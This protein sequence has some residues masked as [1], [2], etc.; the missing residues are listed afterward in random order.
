MRLLFSSLLALTLGI[1][2]VGCCHTS[3]FCDSDCGCGCG[4]DMGCGCGEGGCGEG[5]CGWAN[6]SCGGGMMD[7]PVVMPGGPAFKPQ[8]MQ[9]MPKG[10]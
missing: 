7:V 2:V 8:I 4:C 10:P 9:E 3:G 1:A 6:G 5:G